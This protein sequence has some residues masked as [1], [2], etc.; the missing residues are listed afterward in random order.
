MKTTTLYY[1]YDPMCSWCYA[2]NN[3]FNKLKSNLDDSI[4]IIYIA[5]GLAP[6]SN[7]D[8]PIQM[9]EK[10]QAIWKQ[11][12]QYNGTKFNHD[13]WKNNKPRRSTYLSCMGVISAKLQN[14]EIEMIN[15]IQ[16]AYYVN[17][18]NPSNEDTIISCAKNLGLD[19]NIFEKDLNSKTTL[20]LFENDLNMKRKLNV[21]SFPSLVLKY[22]NKIYPIS[23]DY[24]DSN[25][26]LEQIN[27][28]I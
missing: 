7:E 6:F 24:H 21:N 23:I 4:D 27:K 17:A 9:K 19:I 14:K 20:N 15:E 26:I 18:K 22:D 2:F 10:L 13:F 11:I 3:T 5:G 25:N 16:K 12:S 8:M 28:I 1:I